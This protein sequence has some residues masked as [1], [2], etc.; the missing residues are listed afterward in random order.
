MS[1][2]ICSSPPDEGAIPPEHAVDAAA[3]AQIVAMVHRFYDLCLAD[4]LLGPMFRAEIPEL[5]PHM[6]IVA[7]FWSHALLGTQRYQRG[8][9]Y[10]HHTHLQVEEAHFDRWMAFFS[11]AVGEVLPPDLADTAMKRAAHMTISFRM[12]LLPL[13][14]PGART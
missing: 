5:E 2:P 7:D 6:A 9:P 1:D 11:E 13:P 14:E 3:E 4:D 10:S 8:T 12:G